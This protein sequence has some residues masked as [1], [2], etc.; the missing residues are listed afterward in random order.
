MKS[1]LNV[2]DGQVAAGSFDTAL[3]EC[4]GCCDFLPQE[5]NTE[6][7]VKCSQAMKQEQLAERMANE[8]SRNAEDAKERWKEALR[9][10][11]EMADRQTE[12]VKTMT[13]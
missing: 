1:C 4:R 13:N 12:N 6:C 8:A 7:Q 11:Q 10:L 5:S 9:L 3:S 2:V